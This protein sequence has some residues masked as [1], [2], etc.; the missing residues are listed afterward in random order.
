MLFDIRTVEKA[1]ETLANYLNIEKKQLREYIEAHVLDFDVM[2]MLSDFSIDQSSLKTEDIKLVGFHL[3]SSNCDCEDIMKLGIMDVKHAL[4]SR[5]AVAAF[6]EEQDI[7]FYYDYTYFTY[8]N[9]IY[10][11]TETELYQKLLHESSVHC[12]LCVDDTGYFSEQL[13]IRPEIITM[14]SDI[15]G[16]EIIKDFWDLNHQTYMIRFE[17]DIE[18]FDY[19]SIAQ[20]D[21]LI[22]VIL[23]LICNAV[24]V[25][26]LNGHVEISARMKE[27]YIIPSNRISKVR[28]YY[29]H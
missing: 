16:D 22:D 8:Q 12:F 1:T 28:K 5:T 9:T 4:S 14:I 7:A 26:M 23:E 2:T 29:N 25:M 11:I 27:N 19:N 24:D 6:L 21:E 15:V 10:D 3:T 20:S 18:N 13:Q 17:E